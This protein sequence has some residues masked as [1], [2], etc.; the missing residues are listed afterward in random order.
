MGGQSYPHHHC[1]HHQHQSWQCQ[2]F[3]SLCSSNSFLTGVSE[4][5]P[6]DQYQICNCAYD[7]EQRKCKNLGFCVGCREDRNCRSGEV[8]FDFF[9]IMIMMIMMLKE[10]MIMM[11]VMIMK[12]MMIIRGA[13][14]VESVWGMFLMVHMMIIYMIVWMIINDDW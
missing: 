12:E 11:I 14:Q 10:L 7:Y 3:E 5:F 13:H 6:I 9:A 2:D 4:S 8:G 1:H